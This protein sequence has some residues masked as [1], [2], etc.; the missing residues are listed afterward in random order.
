MNN[1]KKEREVRDAFSGQ[2]IV[3]N[4]DV[5]GDLGVYRGKPKSIAEISNMIAK[6]I[7]DKHHGK[8]TDRDNLRQL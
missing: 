4:T 2:L 3:R 6:A 8:K 5:P 7:K 1:E